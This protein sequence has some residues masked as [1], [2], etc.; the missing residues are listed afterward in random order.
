MRR[1]I[2][3]V[4]I[5]LVLL[6]KTATAAPDELSLSW[7]QLEAAVLG[8][9]VT[10]RL[11]TVTV[12]GHV[13]AVMREG[14]TIDVLKTSNPAVQSLGSALIPRDSITTIETTHQGN[15]FRYL[16][17]PISMAVSFVAY[18]GLKN[19]ISN[20]YARG[21]V[22]PMIGFGVGFGVSSLGRKFARKTTVI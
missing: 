13:L 18:K 11:P 9:R 15:L 4:C 20:R 7:E 3:I 22:A 17:I 8:E 2:A 1:V 19:Q 6:P 5:L 14:L 21:F 10:I 12:N 16:S